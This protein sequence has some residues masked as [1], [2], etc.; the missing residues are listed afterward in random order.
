MPLSTARVKPVAHRSG[1]KAA[2]VQVYPD[3][4]ASIAVGK[5][6]LIA[7]ADG[8]R[9]W[10]GGGGATE[11]AAGGGGRVLGTMEVCLAATGPGGG[12]S[13]DNNVDFVDPG[14]SLEAL[15][16]A[17]HP[18]YRSLAGIVDALRS[19]TP[20]VVLR[21]EPPPPFQAG[22]PGRAPQQRAEE[23]LTLCA[24]MENLPEP[25]FA[26]A[27]ADG[28]S[29][30][31]WTRKSELRV[32]L[33]GGRVRSWAVAAGGEWPAVT[34]I[35]G[36]GAVRGGG[37]GGASVAG[38]GLMAAGGRERAGGCGSGDDDEEESLGYVRAAFVG[39][40]RCLDEE[41]AAY[42]R[43]ATFPVE[44]VEPAAVAPAPRAA[45]SPV[46]S[47]AVGADVARRM[48]RPT[49]DACLEQEK[50]AGQG[51]SG[52]NSKQACGS[53]V[54]S[55]G[56]V[57]LGAWWRGEE[58]G[59]SSNASDSS[60]SPRDPRRVG[61][62]SNRGNGG[63]LGWRDDDGSCRGGG[64]SGGISVDNAGK[65]GRGCRNASDAGS[66][67]DLVY[68]GRCSSELQQSRQYQRPASSPKETRHQSPAPPRIAEARHP[69]VVPAAVSRAAS[70]PLLAPTG[71]ERD[72]SATS[73]ATERKPFLRPQR[74]GQPVLMYS[75]EKLG[76]GGRGG[77]KGGGGEGGGGGERRGR[78]GG[79]CLDTKSSTCSSFSEGYLA[80]AVGVGPAET[81]TG[82]AD[83][84]RRARAG[85]A[86]AVA[87]PR[88]E[89]CRPLPLPDRG[90]RGGAS[91][92]GLGEAFRNGDGDL[93]VRRW[94][95]C[96]REYP[97][98]S[99]FCFGVFCSR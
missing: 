47:W 14:F 88:G 2:A 46:R 57:G 58:D 74:R 71:P 7:S 26:A 65:G 62:P 84:A 10:A 52:S 86:A 44:I 69:G 1:G 49:T 6:W 19:K 20:K 61:E 80:Q 33:P 55:G 38:Y 3:G 60:V 40:R 8:E 39:Y 35:R 82:A 81:T 85:T 70:P 30:S 90:R 72:G 21:R 12:K 66:R 31:L 93:E 78:G 73:D 67:P 98:T 25:D 92:P 94:G 83:P 45:A 59:S 89:N 43:R 75:D 97:P 15:P 22:V 50:E 54:G 63:G 64:G 95:A 9:V 4:R 36:A 56:A 77:G 79:S 76:G 53:G 11:A 99:L 68:S 27:F 48:G 13:G 42:R 17:L 32:E 16:E 24:L 51:G 29:L 28:A 18:L 41:A 34:A 23:N 96:M 87:T 37:G 5:R 91:I